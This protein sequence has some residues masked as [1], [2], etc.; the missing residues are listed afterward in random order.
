MVVSA[1]PAFAAEPDPLDF[2]LGELVTQEVITVARKRQEIGDVAA[3]VHV[4]SAEDIARMG[5]TTLP[6]ALRLVPGVQVAAIGN[7]RWAVSVRGFNGRFA[8]R[9]LVMVDGRTVYSPLFSGTFWEALDI[10]LDEVDRIEV[11]R[12][13]GASIWGAN[14]VNGI[15]NIIT[16]WA[17]ATQGTE[18]RLT[19]GTEDQ[20]LAYLRQGGALEGGHYRISY[21]GRA[22]TSSELTDGSDG[23]DSWHTHRLA[24][25]MERFID[26]L[27]ELGVNADVFSNRSEDLWLVPDLASSPDLRSVRLTQAD[28]GASVTAHLNRVVDEG[29]EW[30]LQGSVDYHDTA[31]GDMLTEN[32]TSVDV[33][34]QYRFDFGRHDLTVGSSV[35][36]HRQEVVGSDYFTIGQAVREFGLVSAFIHDDFALIPK[37][38]TLTAGLKYEHHTWTGNEWQP[39]LR[40]AWNL[41]PR[42]MLWGA[43]SEASRTPARVE[44]DVSYAFQTLP[45]GNILLRITPPQDIA[46]ERMRSYELGYRGQPTDTFHVELTAFEMRYRNMRTLGRESTI[47]PASWI[48]LERPLAFDGHARVNGVEAGLDWQP[49]TRWRARL[50]M[51]YL[52]THVESTGDELTDSAARLFVERVP[53]RQASL[54]VTWKPSSGHVLDAI[55]RHVGELKNREVQGSDTRGVDAYT[56]LD[57]QYAVR[58]SQ[59]VTV[60]LTG[61]NLLHER[62]AEFGRIYMPSP[63]REIGRSAFV[64]VQWALD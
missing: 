7:N 61:R 9:L 8:N 17:R 30:S 10:P 53:T 24:L 56:E 11:I 46:A 14:A 60:S 33:D 16:K 26:G 27:G 37:T 54:H 15:V 35:R 36:Y 40:M 44:Y 47:V 43:V 63:T 45:P 18:A 2:S 57:L 42:H 4:V 23:R 39:N 29:R 25:R 19:V 38:L 20:A 32:R 5:V 22:R 58:L 21:Q 55:V 28:R 62:H 59:A 64:S 13:P 50:A 3:A 6:D 52:G 12:G 51:S 48:T 1:A 41:A 34:G 49:S 31:V